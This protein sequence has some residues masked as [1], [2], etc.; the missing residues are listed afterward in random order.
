MQFDTKY[1]QSPFFCHLSAVLFRITNPSYWLFFM[2]Y[3]SIIILDMKIF[4]YFMKQKLTFNFA[5]KVTIGYSCTYITYRM[6]VSFSH[7]IFS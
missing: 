5:D 4:Y 2:D 1:T 7:A 6:H 3:F